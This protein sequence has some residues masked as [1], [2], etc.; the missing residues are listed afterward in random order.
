MMGLKVAGV[1]PPVTGQ[2]HQPPTRKNAYSIFTM[3]GS[4]TVHDQSIGNLAL[5][6]D[7]EMAHDWP[8]RVF[9]GRGLTGGQ[10]IASNTPC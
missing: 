7:T 4:C 9:R 6:W 8:E 1:G 5:P 3:Q 2:N 10:T